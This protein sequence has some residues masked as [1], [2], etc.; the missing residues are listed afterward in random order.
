MITPLL[1]ETLPV[2]E[3]SDISRVR[4]F[5]RECAAELG[6]GVFDQTRIVTAASELGRNTLIHG[7]GGTM[8]LETLAE[9]DRRGL[10][11]T[12]EDKGPGIPDIEQAMSDGFTTKGGLGLGLGGSKRLVNEFEVVS[13]VGEGTR[14]KVTRWA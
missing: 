6:F 13:R 2:C 9:N 12:F 5:V 10:R 7:G 14:V 11:L 4:Q 1:S 3:A 8:L